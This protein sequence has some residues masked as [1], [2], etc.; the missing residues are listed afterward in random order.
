MKLKDEP[1]KFV[2]FVRNFIYMA[3]DDIS[4]QHSFRMII[5][6]LWSKMHHQSRTWQCCVVWVSN[7][8]DHKNRQCNLA[9]LYIYIYIFRALGSI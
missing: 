9:D 3:T 6:Y 8:Q 7:S 4:H 1:L 5:C 2:S